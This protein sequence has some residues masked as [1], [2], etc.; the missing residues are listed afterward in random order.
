MRSHG[1]SM[2]LHACL[3]FSGTYFSIAKHMDFVAM[4]GQQF[5]GNPAIGR[6]ASDMGFRRI[7]PGDDG[8]FHGSRVSTISPANAKNPCTARLCRWPIAFFCSRECSA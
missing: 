3:D 2:H 8:Y 6:D 4:P 1:N 5:R 7:F